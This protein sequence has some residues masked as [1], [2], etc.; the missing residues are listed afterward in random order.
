MTKLRY[1]THRATIGDLECAIVR[2]DEPP[3][4]VGILC[5]GFGAPGDDLLGL[6]PDLLQART[7]GEPVELIF[8]SA[9]LSLADEGLPDGRAWWRLSIQRLIAMMEMG[10]Y[11]A[12]REESPPGIDQARAALVAVIED[13]LERTGLSGRQLLLGGFSQ[14]AMVAMECACCGLDETPGAMSLFSCC[15]IRE[16]QWRP[17]MP[18]LAETKILQSHGEMDPIL[19]L[20]TGL[21]L[22]DAL[23]DSGCKVEFL[24]FAGPHTISWEAIE[25]TARYLDDLA[26]P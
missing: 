9:L 13:A 8:P 4:A 22:R 7:G 15:L 14:G 24:Q 3:R 21:W 11:E 23:A 2:T 18:K 17:A 19:P 10:Q 12:I 1:R 25:G 6:A 5:H 20:Q 16:R 26:A